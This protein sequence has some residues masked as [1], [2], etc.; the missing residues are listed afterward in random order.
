MLRPGFLL[1]LAAL[2]ARRAVEGVMVALC[3]VSAVI[4]VMGW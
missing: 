3:L 2:A 4:G 1:F